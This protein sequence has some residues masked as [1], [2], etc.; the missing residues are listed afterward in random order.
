M[1]WRATG[2]M[3]IVAIC[4][5][6][7]VWLVGLME[8]SSD[9][10]GAPRRV[11]EPGTFPVEDITRL[12]VARAGEVPL[13]FSR[14]K[15]G[16]KQIE[17]FVIDADGFAVRQLLIAAAD[18]EYSRRFASDQ[19]V[20]GVTLE[21]LGLAP[22]LATLTFTIG[23]RT[24]QIE[25]GRRT[26]AGRGWVRHGEDGDLMVVQDDLHMYGLEDDLRNWRTRNLFSNSGS[27][28]I[29]VL[30]IQ[31]GEVMTRLLRV[32]RTWEMD[33]PVKTRADEEGLHRLARVIADAQHSGFVMDSPE[34]LSKFGLA[35]P[36]ARIVVTRGGE[37]ES[38]LIG[39]QAGLVTND[40]FA[41]V[42]GVPMV[43]RLQEATLR[44]LL[45]EVVSLIQPTASGVR[46]ADVKLI[47]IID[48]D[49][50]SVR[51]ERKLDRW[52]IERRMPD[53]SEVTGE[54]DTA[55]VDGLLETLTLIRAP[56]IIVQDFPS[57]LSHGNVTFFGYDGSP[58][59]TVRVAREA[60]S[61][62]WAIE[63]GDGVLRVFPISTALPISSGMWQVRG[64]VP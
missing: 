47:E 25:M 45:P 50:G 31:N 27:D 9:D 41:Q 46:A 28:E 21:K 20:S 23:D 40:R 63:N 59:D 43:V 14:L 17:P 37:T 49:G 2:L 51:L 35:E 19:L 36:V 6:L 7:L 18:L 32:G 53:G 15:D 12:T 29:D 26:V 58:L 62:R 61:G 11:F 64:T 57:D 8:A 44:A 34:E 30:E 33:A 16:W 22:P 3:W 10:A 52:L 60:D 55:M 48:R 13:V 54:A 4:L 1:S 39:A 24:E 38:L 42:E 5:G 56:E